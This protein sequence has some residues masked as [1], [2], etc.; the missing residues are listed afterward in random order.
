MK[1]LYR[2]EHTPI[3]TLYSEVPEP[4][5]KTTSLTLVDLGSELRNIV[6]KG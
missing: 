2:L 6:R 5:Y 4:D 1:Y 3:Y